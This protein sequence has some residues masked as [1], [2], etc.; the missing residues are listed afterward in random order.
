[1]HARFAFAARILEWLRGL[2]KSAK[3]S[4][5]KEIVL[6]KAWLLRL[7]G[8]RPKNATQKIL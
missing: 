4:T 8:Y 1:M 7:L 6:P 3:K 5:Y 2:Y